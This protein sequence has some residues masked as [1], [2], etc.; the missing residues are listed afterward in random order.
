[1]NYSLT[2]P[3]RDAMHSK[4]L[5]TS[6]NRTKQM[7]KNYHVILFLLYNLTYIFLNFFYL[8]VQ[9]TKDRHANWR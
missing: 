8:N 9:F 5:T 2:T 3:S 1:M 4:I 7:N 6:L